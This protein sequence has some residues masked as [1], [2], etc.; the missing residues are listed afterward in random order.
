[1][2]IVK[3]LKTGVYIDQ[4]NLR[5]WLSMTLCIPNFTISTGQVSGW[6]VCATEFGFMKFE[7]RALCMPGTYSANQTTSLVLHWVLTV[8]C[9][10]ELGVEFSIL[11]YQQRGTVLKTVIPAFGKVVLGGPVGV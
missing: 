7:P 5:V 10:M 2:L 3:N 6:Q 8:T 4:A 11:K 1:M 9:L